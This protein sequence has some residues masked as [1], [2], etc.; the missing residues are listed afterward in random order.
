MLIFVYTPASGACSIAPNITGTRPNRACI[1]VPINVTLVETVI[2]E[3][4]CT[5]NSI[6][7]FLTSTPLYMT[8][9]LVAVYPSQAN[10]YYITLTWTPV[11]DQ[12]GP[13][14]FCAS[15]IDNNGLSGSQYCVNYVVGVGSPDLIQTNLVIGTASP[16]GTVFSNQSIFS[17]QAQY[18]L[19]IKNYMF[20]TGS[21]DSLTVV[22]KI[23]ISPYS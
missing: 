23:W 5:G 19:L 12:Y 18:Q 20:L 8:K 16:V 10:S 22:A 15:P 17:I 14:V 1:G 4:Y 6:V 13:Q 7:E 21:G 3:V 2:A 11:S 9:S